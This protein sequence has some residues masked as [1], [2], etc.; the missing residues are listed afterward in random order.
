MK[1]FNRFRAYEEFFSARALC[2]TG[3]IVIPS[4]LFNPSPL[5]RVVQFL[6]FWFLCRFTGIKNNPLITILVFLG[7]VL[8]NLIMPYGRVLYSIGTF[9]V[10]LG[11]LMMGIHRAATLSGLIMLSRLS[12]RPDLKIPG[13]FG[14]LVGESFRYFALI[15]NSKKRITR[16]NLMADIDRLMI[17]L[18]TEEERATL[19]GHS[20]FPALSSDTVVQIPEPSVKTITS[21]FIILTSVAVIS[22]ILFILPFVY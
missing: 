7:I 17:D 9:N 18:S 2:I 13:G 12:I 5:L 3:L 6:F 8:F 10:T 22:W 19:A 15:M 16:K 11:A 1:R 20:R 21:G 14:A 4:L